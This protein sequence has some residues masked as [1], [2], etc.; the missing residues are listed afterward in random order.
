MGYI[1]IED[2]LQAMLNAADF[3]ACAKPLP[4]NFTMPHVLVDLLN[5][6]DDNP[7]QAV[8]NV[9]FDCRAETY[10]QAAELQCSVANW[11]RNLEGAEVG[12]VPCY[13]VDT[14]RMLRVQPDAANENALLATVS[15]GLRLRI[16]DMR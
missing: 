3:N 6:S 9:D 12:G 8:Y 1:D 2:A 13:K 5:A 7:A 4:A 15:A 10:Q 11:A 16:A 14:L